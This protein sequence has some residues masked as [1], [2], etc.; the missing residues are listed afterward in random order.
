MIRFLND[1][2]CWLAA[3]T[4]V[5]RAVVMQIA[6]GVASVLQSLAALDF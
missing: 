6:G 5:R 1:R 2:I 4:F 3:H